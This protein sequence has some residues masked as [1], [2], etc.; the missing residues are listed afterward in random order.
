MYRPGLLA[1][2]EFGKGKKLSK[3]CMLLSIRAFGITL[4]GNCVP[5]RGSRTV[6]NAP[7]EFTDFEKSP[8]RSNAVGTVTVTGSV[9]VTVCGFSIETKKKALLCT[10][11]LP[12]PNFG[13]GSGPLKLNPGILWR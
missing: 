8:I 12:S 1:I 13:S 4:P 5:V 7:L 3:F 11:A 2:G 6:G 10:K 9:G